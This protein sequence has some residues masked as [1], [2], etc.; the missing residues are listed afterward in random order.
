M[1][2]SFL[3]IRFFLIFL[4]LIKTLKIKGDN[5]LLKNILGQ[6]SELIIEA[7]KQGSYL[8]NSVFYAEG[9]VKITNNYKE[10]I[11]KSKK[12]IFNKLMG[13]FKFKLIGNLVVL[14]T[15]MK[16]NF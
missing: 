5:Y 1:R 4:V 9:V 2:T 14:S 3:K 13:K 15:H 12:A 10:F 6:N 16:K 8:E 11:A 7:N